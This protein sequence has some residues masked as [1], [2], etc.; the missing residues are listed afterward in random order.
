MSNKEDHSIE[1][2]K[3]FVKNHPA[4]VKDVRRGIY[5][6]QE[7]FED[8]YILGGE[9]R[10][11][12]EYRDSDAVNLS[13]SEKKDKE[14]KVEK[15]MLSSIFDSLKNVDVQSMQKHVSNLSQALGTISGVISQ[16]QKT[17]PQSESEQPKQQNPLSLRRD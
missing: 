4:L 11:W 1:E 13:D 7:V 8:W 3:D 15:D 2:F 12:D 5:T 6:W 17:T 10:L 16:F 9:D 14:E